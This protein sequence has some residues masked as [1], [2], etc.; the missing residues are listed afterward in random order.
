MHYSHHSFALH[1]RGFDEQGLFINE[2]VREV[3]HHCR[4]NGLAVLFDELTPSNP[5]E[6]LDLGDC[7][8]VLVFVTKNL[9]DKVTSQLDNCSK[10][11]FN[12]ALHQRNTTV[13][14]PIV[15][16]EQMLDVSLWRGPGGMVRVVA[17]FFFIR[18]RFP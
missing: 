4:E 16:E 2:R 6:H 7:L 17:V 12:S 10:T 18:K 3:V 8:S 15:I 1:D 14:I 9:V 11:R 5:D 13:M